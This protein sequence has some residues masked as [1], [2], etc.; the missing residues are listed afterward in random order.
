MIPVFTAETPFELQP[1]VFVMPFHVPFAMP[2]AGRLYFQPL[3]I[4]GAQPVL[5]DTGGVRFTELYLKTLSTLID[6]KDVRWIFLSH[7]D[8]DHAG[9]VSALLTHCPQARLITSFAG[10]FKLF[11]HMDPPT[12]LRRA[13]LLNPGEQL[14]VGD[15]TLV[16]I[17]PPLFDSPSS[18]GLFDARS[19]V[20]FTVD[21]Y[22]AP[23]P[24]Y[25]PFAD[26]FDPEVFTR[27]FN[28][29]ARFNYPWHEFVDIER[30]RALCAPLVDFAPSAVVSY[31]GPIH[32]GGMEALAAR[33]LDVCRLPPAPGLTQAE[34]EA[35]L[36][37]QRA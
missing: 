29:W 15:R 1:D 27:G 37:V 20:L 5:V 2:G 14:D 32:R 31:H 8:G 13:Y 11:E 30:M 7:E 35:L 12:I 16:A 34:L 9:G 18:R 26:A 4:R 19:R 25:E 17:R 28:L 36:D 33:T 3:L 10:L 24:H 23:V 6:P 22:G 21:A